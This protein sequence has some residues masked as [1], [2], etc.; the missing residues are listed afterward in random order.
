MPRKHRIPRRSRGRCRALVRPLLLAHV[1]YPELV[2]VPGSKL[3]TP[4]HP[5]FRRRDLLFAGISLKY[6]DP[7]TETYLTD[8]NVPFVN[9]ITAVVRHAIGTIRQYRLPYLFPAIPAPWDDS[10]NLRFGT[11]AEFFAANALPDSATGKWR[12]SSA[13]FARDLDA[14]SV[15]LHDVLDDGQPKFPCRRILGN[16]RSPR[17]RSAFLVSGMGAADFVGMGQFPV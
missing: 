1:A 14:P 10:K 11:N 2:L 13:R 7:D 3:A 15:T 9:D 5:S 16:G 6:W 8:E 4:E 12:R 17:G